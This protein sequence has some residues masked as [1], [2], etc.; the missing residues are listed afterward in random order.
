[1]YMLSYISL[2]LGYISLCCKILYMCANF[3]T[4]TPCF[5]NLLSGKSFNFEALS[6]CLNVNETNTPVSL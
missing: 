3:V 1:M 6:C 2:M 5:S 4:L